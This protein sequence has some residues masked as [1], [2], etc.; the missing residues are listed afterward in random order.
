MTGILVGRIE[1]H[2]PLQVSGRFL[3]RPAVGKRGAKMPMGQRRIGLEPQ[4]FA[5]LHD[6]LVEQSL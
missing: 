5:E 1:L 4:G 2:G 6:S 3:E